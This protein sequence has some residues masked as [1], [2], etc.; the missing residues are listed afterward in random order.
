MKAKRGRP[1]K[2][3]QRTVPL[4]MRM[5]VSEYDRLCREAGRQDLATYVR[6]QVVLPEFRIQK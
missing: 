4:A 6:N 5:P 3:G 1:L 2:F